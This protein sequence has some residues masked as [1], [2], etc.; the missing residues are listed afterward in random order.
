MV[1]R[2]RGCGQLTDAERDVPVLVVGGGPVGLSLAAELG[3]H[4]VR[5]LLV[6][7]NPDINHHPRANVVSARSMEH[8]CRWGIAHDVEDGGLPRDYPVEIVFTT[9]VAGGEFFRFSFPSIEDAEHPTP[10][11]LAEMPELRLSP[12]F[13]TS[14][15]QNHLERVIRRHVERLPGVELRFGWRLDAFEDRGDRVTATI[16]DTASGATETLDVGYLAGCDGGRSTIRRRLGIQ[17]TG[18]GEL[19]QFVSIHFRSEAFGRRHASGRATLYWALNGDSNG[20]FIA[21]DG[22][23]HFTFQRE[24]GDHEDA[25]SIDAQAAIDQAFGE[26]LPCEIL[27]VQ[28]WTAQQLVAETYQRGRVFL[29][30]DAAHLFVPTG[31]F[32]MNTGIGDAI[33]LGWKLAA[34]VDGWGGPALLRSYTAERRPIGVRNTIEAA[35]NYEKIKPAFALGKDAEFGRPGRRSRARN[36]CR[37]ARHRA[38]AFRRD[39]H[40]PRLPLRGLA[41]RRPGRIAADARR[42]PALRPDR[43]AGVARAARLA[44][45]RPLHPRP[46]RPR[47]RPAPP[48]RARSRGRRPGA[49][50][51]GCRAAAAG[52]RP[53]RPQDRGALRRRPRPGASRR[54][55]GVA[56]RPGPGGPGGNP[57]HCHGPTR[58]ECGAAHGRHGLKRY[59]GNAAS[60]PGDSS[61][62][63]QKGD[64]MTGSDDTVSLHEVTIPLVRQ[65]WAFARDNGEWDRLRDCFEPDADIDISW[66]RGGIEDF[67]DGSR[68]SL[69]ARRDGETS[70][71]WIGKS[72][73]WVRGDK[74]VVQT[75][76]VVMS[77]GYLDDHL[78][79]FL[80]YGQ[81]HDRMVFREGRWR[82]VKWN[83]VYEKDRMDAVHPHLVPADFYRS[84]DVSD[85]PASC[86]FLC[87]RLARRGHTISR[88]II[89]AG[90]PEEDALIAASRAWLEE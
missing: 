35:D 3:Y 28:P 2:A 46:V 36:A 27:S 74:A 12:Y 71:H 20:C 16:V 50:R 75:D 85:Y 13:K 15:G 30:G 88:S 34:T 45:R 49:G 70:K 52:R 24:L 73:C 82:I 32:G 5:C 11:L 62:T 37:R 77:R 58:T 19:G 9:R 31:G 61:P 39:G 10:E 80:S 53:R 81:A 78:F 90:S 47:L 21:I 59:R 8:F 22:K 17:L 83:G 7:R 87:L 64:G 57:R 55:R 14:I 44:R 29:A 76:A 4:G 54:P 51:V 66:F 63:N 6:E 69:A 43:A 26:A 67:I 72:R 68:R 60:N 48:R 23:D 38:Q 84:L 65:R 42:S 40:P 33:D 79:D 1:G 89:S 25:A 41:G 18:R 86:A 56:R